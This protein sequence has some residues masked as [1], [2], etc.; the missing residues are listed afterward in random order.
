MHPCPVLLLLT[1]LPS[2]LG[3]DC[4]S[5]QHL[6]G[7]TFWRRP[8]YSLIR[9]M[10]R[11]QATLSSQTQTSGDSSE[12]HWSDDGHVTCCICSVSTLLL[13]YVQYVCRSHDCHVTSVGPCY[14]LAGSGVA[15]TVSPPAQRCTRCHSRTLC[16]RLATKQRH[17]MNTLNTW[18]RLVCRAISQCVVYC[19][20]LF[21]SC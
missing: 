10:T 5:G 21:V 20:C 14:C 19:V 1:L 9:C 16:C 2:I 11:T 18:K 8:T 4:T 13:Q 15:C 6:C 12:Q 3:P 7:T 17:C